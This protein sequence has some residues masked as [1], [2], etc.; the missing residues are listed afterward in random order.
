[1]NIRGADD[2]DAVGFPV[3]GCGSQKGHDSGLQTEAADNLRGTLIDI[4][5]NPCVPVNNFFGSYVFDGHGRT[6]G[7]VIQS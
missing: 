3:C 2:M 1:M 4:I 7:S 5:T 6:K